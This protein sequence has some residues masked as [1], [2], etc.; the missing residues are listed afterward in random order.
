[1]SNKA[2]QL[3]SVILEARID[4]QALEK[5]DYPTAEVNPFDAA[6]LAWIEDV[7]ERLCAFESALANIGPRIHKETAQGYSDSFE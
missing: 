3:I 7:E 2:L 5:R 6:L 4:E 1:M